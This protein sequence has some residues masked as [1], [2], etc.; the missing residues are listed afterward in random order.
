MQH[1]YE[2]NNEITNFLNY[3]KAV[4][5]KKSF[6]TKNGKCIITKRADI[7]RFIL[8]DL[9]YRKIV[10]KLNKIYVGFLILIGSLQFSPW[11]W[12]E[13]KYKMLILPPTYNPRTLE[14]GNI[15]HLTKSG[16][17]RCCAVGLMVIFSRKHD[18]NCK[19]A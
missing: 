14:I 9:D 15:F 17:C 18:E 16:V 5:R 10:K 8:Q 1:Y 3:R 4:Q 13:S 11:F 6:M 19:D 7:P 12:N 2:E